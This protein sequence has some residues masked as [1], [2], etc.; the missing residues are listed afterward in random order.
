MLLQPQLLSHS[1]AHPRSTSSILFSCTSRPFH[2]TFCSAV[3]S[4]PLVTMS[5][6]L[7]SRSGAPSPVCA[8]S[9]T[10]QGVVTSRGLAFLF[11]LARVPSWQG[12]GVCLHHFDLRI[13]HDAGAQR[14]LVPWNRDKATRMEAIGW[15]CKNWQTNWWD[16]KE[17]GRRCFPV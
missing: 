10:S 5:S 4:P 13:W 15:H 3:A 11:P 1:P 14:M 2:Q 7:K 8:L 17:P 9:P 16:W 12:P 6:F